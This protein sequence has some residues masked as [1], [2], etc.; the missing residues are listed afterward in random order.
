MPRSW[1]PRSRPSRRPV[2]LAVVAAVAALGAGS[3]AAAAASPT[4]AAAKRCA[5]VAG[6]T[7]G[8]T[9]AQVELVNVRGV[10]CAT[11]RKVIRRCLTRDSVRGWTRTAATAA[12]GLR[13][14]RRRIA[15]RVLSHDEPRCVEH[16]RIGVGAGVHRN[17]R[18]GT[19]RQAGPFQGPAVMPP[20]SRPQWQWTSPVATNAVNA[21][22]VGS[23][24]L[25]GQAHTTDDDVRSVWFEYGK[26]RDLAREAKTATQAPKVVAGD[27]AWSFG[28]PLKG[29]DAKTRYYWRAAANLDDGTNEGRTVYGATGSFV[30]E[31]Y[32][33]VNVD[34]PCAQAVFGG[35]EGGVTQV[36]EALTLVCSAKMRLVNNTYTPLSVAYKGTLTCP[37]DYPKNLNAGNTSATIPKIDYTVYFN[38][39]VNFWR[40]NNSARFTDFFDQ[41]QKH[42]E[43]AEAGPLVGWHEWNIDEWGSLGSTNATDVQVWIHCTDNWK[44]SS[45]DQLARGEGSDQPSAAA[46]ATPG[47]FRFVRTQGGWRG[48]WDAVRNVPAGIAGYQLQVNS[49]RDAAAAAVVVTETGTS[50][51]LSD[52]YIRA[53]AGIYRTKDLYAHVWAI[54]GEGVR[55][56]RSEVIPITAP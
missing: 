28:Q 8:S 30:T 18:A 48:S 7:S 26:T 56:A 37:R 29:L 13:D 33:K 40:S 36:T 46:P 25:W 45:P 4:A 43:G 31:G 52:A 3:T 1:S 39:I 55:S 27:V 34:N 14:G 12:P 16:G 21:I 47:D 17:L 24:T 9:W 54:S 32:R 11:A 50:G 53:M 44:A 5:P 22:E 41:Y 51:F 42:Y 49:V 19:L 20:G 10:S 6:A 23:A 38:R 2:S 15:L 35:N